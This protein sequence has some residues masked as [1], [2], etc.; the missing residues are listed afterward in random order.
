MLG[1]NIFRLIGDLFEVI[2]MPF[3]YLRLTVAKADGGWWTS[4]ALNW[5]FLI[6][7]IVILGYW[8]NECFRFKREGTEDR[9]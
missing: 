9:A 4:N 2:L 3:Q 5:I 6:V 8:M 1:L 7:L